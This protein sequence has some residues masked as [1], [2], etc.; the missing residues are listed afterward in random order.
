MIVASLK[1]ERSRVKSS[2]SRPRCT[3]IGFTHTSSIPRARARSSSGFQRCPVGSQPSTTPTNPAAAAIGAAQSSTSS[4][5]QASPVN[6]RR[7]NTTES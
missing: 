5:T 7:P 3:S 2:S 4:I 1:S 6:I